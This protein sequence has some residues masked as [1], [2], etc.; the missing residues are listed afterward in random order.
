MWFNPSIISIGKILTTSSPRWNSCKSDWQLQ[1]IL[2]G[3][4]WSFTT[5]PAKSYCGDAVGACVTAELIAMQV[6]KPFYKGK[7]RGITQDDLDSA[8]ADAEAALKLCQMAIDAHNAGY[9]LD[10]YIGKI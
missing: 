4:Q 5:L 9:S 3:R 1:A 6:K 10:Q 8:I 7:T 2:R